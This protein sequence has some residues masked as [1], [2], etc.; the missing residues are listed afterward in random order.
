MGFLRGNTSLR[1]IKLALFDIA[2]DTPGS[3]FQLI[4]LPELQNLSLEMV[5]SLIEW[6][7]SQL[8]LVPHELSLNI[9]SWASYNDISDHL[10]F[11]NRIRFSLDEL[12][13]RRYTYPETGHHSPVSM[14]HSRIFTI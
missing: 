9:T 4:E 7:L 6:F 8:V 12:E 5:P 11:T 10:G 1:S 2:F 13:S 14:G 3:S